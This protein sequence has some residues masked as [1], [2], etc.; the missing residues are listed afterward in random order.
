MTIFGWNDFWANQFA[1]YAAQGHE[2]GRIFLDHGSLY[3]VYS[4]KGELT[5]QISGKIRYESLSKADRPAIGD[6]VAIR[7]QETDGAIIHAVL[8]RKSK[9][10]RQCAGK[11]AEEQLVAANID[12]LFLVSG[13]DK[14]LNLRRIERY[15]LLAWEGGSKAVIVLNKADLCDDVERRIAEVQTVAMGVP[16]VV[17]SAEKVSGLS[18]LILHCPAGETV[19][20]LGSSGVGKSSLVNCLLGQEKQKVHGVSDFKDKGRHT[21]THR[22]LFLLEHGGMLIDTPGMRELQLWGGEESLHST[23]EDIEALAQE[24]RFRNCTHH[25]EPDCAVKDA[26]LEDRLDARRLA[27][28]HKLQKEMAFVE[29]KQNH[30]ALLRKSVGGKKS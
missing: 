25:H 30:F 12:T 28:Y 3:R 18:E 16:I 5:A 13:L 27:S 23:F 22:Q 15:L 2:A 20:L 24:C 9:F 4:Q 29:R 10:S 11:K 6:W 14:D 26:I 17:T 7:V 1:P 19:A 8:P 21:T